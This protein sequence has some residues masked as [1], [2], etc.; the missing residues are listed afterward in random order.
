MVA[1]SPNNFW[2]GGP[3]NSGGAE[4]LDVSVANEL[5]LIKMTVDLRSGKIKAASLVDTF[6]ILER[7]CRRNYNDCQT[8]T[9]HHQQRRITVELLGK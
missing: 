8:P 5:I 1:G 7:Q 3:S 4:Y 9:R 6:E 2:M